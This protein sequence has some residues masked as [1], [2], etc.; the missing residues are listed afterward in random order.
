MITF[1]PVELIP[2]FQD[3]DTV[4][5]N[6]ASFK[7]GYYNLVGLNPY[8]YYSISS[9]Q[10]YQDEYNFDMWYKSIIETNPQANREFIDMMRYVYNGKNIYILVDF[11]FENINNLTESLIKYITEAFGYT[12]NIVH[13][14]G[15]ILYSKEGSFSPRGVKLMDQLLEFYLRRYDFSRLETGND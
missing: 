13:E 12:C 5:L 3:E 4:I 11:R 9:P 8:N 1:G 14:V 2:Y 10:N 6:L 15:D 7:E